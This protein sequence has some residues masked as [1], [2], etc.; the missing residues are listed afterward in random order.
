MGLENAINTATFE[1]LSRRRYHGKGLISVDDAQPGNPRCAGKLC[2]RLAG[3]SKFCRGWNICGHAGWQWGCSFEHPEDQWPTFNADV[4]LDSIRRGS[5]KFDEIQTDMHRSMP[6]AHIVKID[7][8][9]NS[10]LESLYDQ[11]RS[12][13]REKQGFAVEKELW[14]GTSVDAIPILLQHGLQPPADRRASDKCPTSGGKGLCTTLC[15]T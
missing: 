15:G 12:F 3:P 6:C 8:V 14:H 10:A 13:I 2:P 4:E 1:Q 7:R 5:A 11:R 9:R